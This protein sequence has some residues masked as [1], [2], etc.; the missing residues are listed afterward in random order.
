MKYSAQ[1][2]KKLKKFKTQKLVLRPTPISRLEQ[3]SAQLGVPDL[4]I[5]REDLTGLAFGG[6]KSRKLEYIMQD[7]I[8]S[9]SDVVITW[10]SV[11]SNW[12]LQTAAAARKFGIKPILLLFQT[13]ETE[14]IM[15]GNLLLDFILDSDIRIMDAKKGQVVKAEEVEAL[16]E[17]VQNQVVEWGHKPYIIPIGGSMVG[18]SMK[19]PLGAVAYVDVYLE[20]RRQMESLNKKADWIVLASGSGG[21]QAGLAAG[22]RLCGDDTKVAGISV[23]ED[24]KGFSQEIREISEDVMTC[25]DLKTDL[26]EEDILVFDDY[27]GAGYGTLDKNVTEAIKMMAVHEGIFMDPIYTGKAVAALLDLIKKSIIKKDHT[28][29]ILHTGGTPVLFPYKKGIEKFLTKS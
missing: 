10:G 19:K 9:Q 27:I 5:K 21:T 4:F 12:C 2:E 6:N 17:V 7:V 25:L 16:L 11:Q 3:I 26:S 1:V 23:S 15:D 18:G 29:L 20:L 22:A 14:G 28:V 13:Y 24:T 8:D